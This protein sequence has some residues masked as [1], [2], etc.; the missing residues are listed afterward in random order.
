MRFALKIIN[1]REIKDRLDYEREVANHE[2]VYRR[3]GV[4]RIYGA[5]PAL[6]QITGC[7]PTDGFAGIFLPL[8]SHGSLEDRLLEF[9]KRHP[10]KSGLPV[11]MVRYILAKIIL[12]SSVCMAA[13]F[14]PLQL[15]AA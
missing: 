11:E 8:A 12:V 4:M 10:H 9:F 13:R 1:N 5:L 3:S 2:R 7:P 15:A 6:P 14:A